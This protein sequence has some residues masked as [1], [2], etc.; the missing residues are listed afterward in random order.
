M[1]NTPIYGWPYQHRLQQP[2]LSPEAIEALALA[3]EATVS[4]LLASFPVARLR[5]T[6]AQAIPHNAFTAVTWQVAD[7]DTAGG[8]N[9]STNPSRYTFQVPGYYTVLSHAAFAA[10]ATGGRAMGVAYNG[11][12]LA[13]GNVLDDNAG[14][15]NGYHPSSGL[16]VKAAS[17]GDYIELQVYQFSG[18]N[19]D[20]EV[21][22]DGGPFLDITFRRSL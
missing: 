10:N 9:A 12:R 4:G 16:T 8:W 3:I 15:G 17:V 5:R 2:G 7:W 1:P 22:A 14:A 21:S 6:S 19:L 11:T 13:A 20:Q 18:A